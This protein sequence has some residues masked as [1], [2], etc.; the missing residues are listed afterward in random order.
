MAQTAIKALIEW[1]ISLKDKEQKCI[2]WICIKSKAEE[3]LPMEK[4]QIESAYSTG[5]VSGALTN[6]FY[7]NSKESSEQYY[8]E[9]Y[10]K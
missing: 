6:E 1:A 2:D 10:K 9:T 8:N 4:E 5:I 7:E 3:L